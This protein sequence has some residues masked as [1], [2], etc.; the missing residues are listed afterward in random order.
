MTK[1]QW[2]IVAIATLIS[3]RIGYILSNIAFGWVDRGL[4]SATVA[5]TLV[6]ATVGFLTAL[7]LYLDKAEG[8][9]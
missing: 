3:G 5:L 6:F 7:V 1:I 2:L 8:V 9:K 4:M